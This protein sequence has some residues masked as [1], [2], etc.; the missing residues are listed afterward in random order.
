MADKVKLQLTPFTALEILS[1]LKEFQ[2]V[3]HP[4]WKG[5]SECITEYETEVYARTSM[6][7]LEDA[8]AQRSVNRLLKKSP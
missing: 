5:L 1:F 2:D 7:Q 6:E 8:E 3:H 4:L